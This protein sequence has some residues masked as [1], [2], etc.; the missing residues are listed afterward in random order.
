MAGPC[1]YFREASES[2]RRMK[3]VATIQ[4][5]LAGLFKRGEA[6]VNLLFQKTKVKIKF[7]K[8]ITMI[9]V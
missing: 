2:H 6:Q 3:E 5:N 7:H 8:I 4:E 9:I 1:K